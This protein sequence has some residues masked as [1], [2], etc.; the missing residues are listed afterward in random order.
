[1]ALL[2]LLLGCGT[3]EPERPPDPYS[4]AGSEAVD[5]TLGDSLRLS[6]GG[7]VEVAMGVPVPFMLTLENVSGR[8]LDLYLRGRTIAFDIVV[9]DT[10]GA[11]IWRRLEGEM[12]PAVLRLETLAPGQVLE[13][14]GQWDQRDNA[15]RPVRAGDYTAYG[16]LLTEAAP[17]RTGTVTLRIVP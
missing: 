6:L 15:G 16:E 8:P 11:T 9:L 10:A 12:I 1:V 3:S 17:L 7:P 4:A 13:L 5:I 2:A 14:S